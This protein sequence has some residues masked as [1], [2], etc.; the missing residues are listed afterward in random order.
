MTCYRE[1]QIWA[2][3]RNKPDAV[4]VIT[5]VYKRLYGDH[6]A[7]RWFAEGLVVAGGGATSKAEANMRSLDADSISALFPVM[8]FEFPN[9]PDYLGAAS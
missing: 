9:D 2:N 4:F 6:P 7:R 8:K 5:K 1:G 3:R